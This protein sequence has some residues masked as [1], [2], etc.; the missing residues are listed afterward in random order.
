MDMQNAIA[1]F[2]MGQPGRCATAD[3]I[4]EYMRTRGKHREHVVS[5]LNEMFGN[6]RLMPAGKGR[7]ELIQ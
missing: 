4:V 6:G 7:L 2:L 1:V 5:T 3:Q